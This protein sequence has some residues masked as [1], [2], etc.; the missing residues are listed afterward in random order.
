MDEWITTK[1]VR[2]DLLLARSIGARPAIRGA[3]YVALSVLLWSMFCRIP[4]SSASAAP[5][6]LR[7]V[8]VQSNASDVYTR[9]AE[10]IAQ[11]LDEK[12]D[13]AGLDCVMTRFSLDDACIERCLSVAKADVLVTLGQKAAALTAQTIDAKHSLNALITRTDYQALESMPGQSAVYLD[14]PWSRQL[15][16]IELALPGRHRIGLMLS[17]EKA[18]TLPMPIASDMPPG[19]RLTLRSLDDPKRL[20]AELRRLYKEVDLLLALPDARIHNARSAVNLLLSSYRAKIP[21]LAFSH[22]Y[23]SAGAL[24]AVYSTPEQIARQVADLL[25][26]YLDNPDQ[27]LPAPAHP[28]YFSVSVNHG[29][30]RSLKLKLPAAAVLERDLRKESP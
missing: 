16:L 12:C 17:A 26:R 15:R 21:V 2:T 18:A 25:D 23:V 4:V 20:G 5:G 28:T 7:F 10:V 27:G 29:V 19:M 11:R 8:L 1:K 3:L 22:A 13:T 6:S 9:A 24:L 30:A 14:Q